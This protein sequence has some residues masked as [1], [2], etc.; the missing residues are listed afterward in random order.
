MKKNASP[1]FSSASET[2][3]GDKFLLI[4]DRCLTLILWLISNPKA[5]FLCC[6]SDDRRSPHARC[7]YGIGNYGAR[8]GHVSGQGGARSDSVES[9]AG[10]IGGRSGSG[11]QSGGSGTGRGSGVDGRCR[12]GCSRR[13]NFRGEWRGGVP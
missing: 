11:A 8:D 3:Q 13:R 12:Y 2:Q 4:R 10:K 9:N 7:V 1:I 6:S 5:F